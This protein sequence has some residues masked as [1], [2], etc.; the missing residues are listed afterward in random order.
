[1]VQEHWFVK[2]PLSLQVSNVIITMM[3]MMML[4]LD[5]DIDDDREDDIGDADNCHG[6]AGA[7]DVQQ[8][9]PKTAGL[10]ICVFCISIPIYY[11][12]LF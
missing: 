8:H 1:M 6:R 3:V 2:I 11:I 9:L 12:L 4:N 7:G 5:D 10:L